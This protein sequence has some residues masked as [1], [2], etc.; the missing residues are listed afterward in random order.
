MKRVK[1]LKISDYNVDCHWIEAV[2]LTK[3]TQLCISLS[4]HLVLLLARVKIFWDSFRQHLMLLLNHT[5]AW[6]SLG[7][8]HRVCL[9][10]IEHSLGIHCFRFTRPLL[11]VDISFNQ[12]EISWTI[13]FCDTVINRAFTFYTA[14][15][16]RSLP[17]C[18]CSVRTR[19]A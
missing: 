16:F 1:I 7:T 3:L 17:Q 5:F 15:V 2:I 14:N 19:K 13:W 8:N 6:Y 18:Y 4:G 10:G 12:I 11:I 9:N